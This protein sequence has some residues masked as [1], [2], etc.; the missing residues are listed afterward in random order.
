MSFN[1]QFIICSSFKC[2]C[3]NLLRRASLPAG[4][5]PENFRGQMSHLSACTFPDF[6]KHLFRPYQ[7]LS[8][9][10]SSSFANEEHGWSGDLCFRKPV[11]SSQ[12]KAQRPPSHF[13]S[14]AVSALAY[15]RKRLNCQYP[16]LVSFPLPGF[17]YQLWQ[18]ATINDSRYMHACYH[19]HHT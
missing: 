7:S 2:V 11:F 14:L 4:L 6:S 12:W 1:P 10:I 18:Y 19:M 5:F 3:V 15:G 16:S 8:H 9:N 17:S 13:T